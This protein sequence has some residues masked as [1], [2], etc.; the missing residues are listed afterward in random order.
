MHDDFG[1]G[2]TSEVEIGLLEHLELE[3]FVVGQ[4]SIEGERKPLGLLDMMTFEGLGVAFI[5]GAAGGVADVSDGGVA[6]VIGHE[7][8]GAVEVVHQ[9]DFGDGANVFMGIDELVAIA[10]EGGHPGGELATI[11]H[12]LQDLRHQESCPLGILMG[13]V[14]INGQEGME[15]AF[16]SDSFGEVIDCRNSTFVVQFRHESI[17]LFTPVWREAS[18]GSSFSREKKGAP[19]PR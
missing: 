9:E 17:V 11:L 16:V 7:T 1:I 4:L 18:A 3:V 2:L 19:E 13:V 8:A 14:G 5:F 6:F 15:T 10:V 12:V